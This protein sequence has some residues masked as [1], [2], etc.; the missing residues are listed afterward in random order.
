MFVLPRIAG[1]GGEQALDRGRRVGR[2]VALEDAR[3]GRGGQALDAEDVL[4][5]DRHAAER[6]PSAESTRDRAGLLGAPEVG[7]ERRR[8]GPRRPRT[9]RR[10]RGRP[11]SI[12]ARASATVRSTRVAHACGEGT[13]NES[14][15]GSGAPASAGS[16]SRLGRRLVRPEH[17]LERLDVRG[18]LDPVEVELGDRLDV[19]ED[20]GELARHALDLVLVEAEPRKAGDV[21]DLVAI[22]HRRRIVGTRPE[23]NA[24]AR[25]AAALEGSSS[26][27]Q[28]AGGGWFPGGGG[29]APV[30]EAVALRG[31]RRSPPPAWPR[32]RRRRC[33]RRRSARGRRRSTSRRHEIVDVDVGTADVASNQVRR[34]DDPEEDQQD[35]QDPE[36]RR[37]SR[38]R[39]RAGSRS[40]RSRTSPPRRSRR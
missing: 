15:V 40:A 20:P 13:R 25:M 33:R 27:A 10:P 29:V 36:R 19:L 21:E 30:L 34:A 26:P 16:R 35:R 11:A 12:S 2:H 38:C 23:T 4:D 5:R 32:S 17:V 24:A 22:D 37:R 31:R 7:A 14:P 1:A 8:S 28:T 18:R 3:A 6:P 39:R 9:T